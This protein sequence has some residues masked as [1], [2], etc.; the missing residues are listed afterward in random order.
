ML[1]SWSA[2]QTT[3]EREQQGPLSRPGHS[4]WTGFAER[5]R[6]T[7][8]RR[9]PQANPG[10][11]Y[12][13]ARVAKHPDAPPPP[14]LSPASRALLPPAHR[15]NG[16][17]SDSMLQP[18][19]PTRALPPPLRGCEQRP[20]A[21]NASTGCT[22]VNHALTTTVW[23]CDRPRARTDRIASAAAAATRTCVS[24]PPP[25][26]ADQPSN[27]ARSGRRGV[28]RGVVLPARAYRPL[29]SATS[30][31]LSHSDGD[32]TKR[33]CQGIS[34]GTNRQVQGQGAAPVA[35]PVARDG[36]RCRWDCAG[37]RAREGTAWQQSCP[38]PATRHVHGA[39][40]FSRGRPGCNVGDAMCRPAANPAA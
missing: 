29:C 35:R 4:G 30:L 9:G 19:Y 11:I 21:A 31:R 20:A 12:Y 24:C 37:R 16:F 26:R 34:E 23:Q 3:S 40:Q 22:R 8:A 33:L 32:E 7:R 6:A 18:D 2:Q 17:E 5:T 25:A 1:G 28:N 10:K 27:L 13:R 14:S 38:G 39:S 15:T 36:R